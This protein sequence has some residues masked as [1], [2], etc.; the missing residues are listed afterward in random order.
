MAVYFSNRA[1]LFN[2]ED[3]K[4]LLKGG[5]VGIKVGIISM[6]DTSFLRSRLLN[7]NKSIVKLLFSYHLS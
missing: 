4:I 1:T 7:E 5:G 3:F 2:Y 6:V